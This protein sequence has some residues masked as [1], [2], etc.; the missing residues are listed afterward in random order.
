MSGSGAKLSGTVTQYA[1]SRAETDS[2]QP[3]ENIK[4]R[5]SQID[6]DKK[7][8]DIST[9]TDGRYSLA[10]LPTGKYKILPSLPNGLMVE[11][12][13]T[14]EFL[15]NDKG[16]AVKDFLV[17]NSSMV[18]GKVVDEKGNLVEDIRVDLIPVNLTS[19]KFAASPES[20]G[21]FEK[22]FRMYH[23]PA[24][25]YYLAANYTYVPS[26]SSP[27]KTTFYGKSGE[28]ADATIIEVKQGESIEGLTIKLSEPLPMTEIR[29]RVF[30]P[31]GKPAK[32]VDINLRDFEARQNISDDKTNA[33]GEFV[34]KGFMGR[35][36]II[37]TALF[38]RSVDIE[39]EAK[40]V[41]FTL[42][43]KTGEFK[44]MLEKSKNED[45]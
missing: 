25:K 37:E 26:E 16:C 45:R 31:D 21:I 41:V 28:L 7:N 14:S 32:D 2:E 35:Q 8:F 17:K 29:G 36:Y 42:D 30:F 22:E 6:G 43:E 20:S 38:G 23:V 15:L 33:K 27:Y 13:Q 10:N 4:L 1:K 18:A 24:G 34:V 11:D 9:G 40:D 5:V 19:K 44:L 39:Y 12:Y 3:L